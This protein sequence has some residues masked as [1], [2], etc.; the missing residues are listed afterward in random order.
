MLLT[1]LLVQLAQHLANDLAHALQRFEVVLRLVVVALG[2]GNLFLHCACVGSRV[3]GGGA[4]NQPHSRARAREKRMHALWL[5]T[6]R[7][8]TLPW[9]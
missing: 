1:S 7:P 9:M 5:C 6:H 8:S 3:R 2:L 4:T